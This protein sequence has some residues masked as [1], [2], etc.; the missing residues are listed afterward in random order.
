MSETPRL[1][2][3]TYSADYETFVLG[4]FT[5]EDGAKQWAP[6]DVTWQPRNAQAPRTLVG[7]FKGRRDTVEIDEYDVNAA[8][9]W[10]PWATADS[11][12]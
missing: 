5:S 6:P 1:Y 8:P 12:R 3:L 4:V 2:V 7:R 10:L 11:K 9:K